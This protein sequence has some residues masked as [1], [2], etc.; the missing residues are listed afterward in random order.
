MANHQE[1]YSSYRLWRF[2][3]HEVA[4]VVRRLLCR[5]AHLFRHSKLEYY[6]INDV[7][8]IASEIDLTEDITHSLFEA[9][10]HLRL[11][12]REVL[13]NLRHA[14]WFLVCSC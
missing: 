11:R 9:G 10:I 14:L 6:L 4:Q 5:H 7:F 3:L 2:A 12:S 8:S 13:Q 1:S